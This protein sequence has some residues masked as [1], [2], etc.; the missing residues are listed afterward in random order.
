ML[1]RPVFFMAG[2]Y[3]GGNRY[4]VRF[5]RL[6]DFSSIPRERRQAEIDEAMRRYAAKLEALVRE[7][8][9]NWFNFYDFWQYK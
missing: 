1:R 4:Q 5:E 2:L 7:S 3:L 6:A 9:W 8:P